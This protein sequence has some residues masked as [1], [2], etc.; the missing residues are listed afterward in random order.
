MT[1]A[2]CRLKKLAPLAFIALLAATLVLAMPAG[3]ARR[4]S[5]LFAPTAP[6]GLAVSSATTS[7]VSL[8]WQPSTDNVRVASYVT[9]IGLEPVAASRKTNVTIRALRC[10]TSYWT[11]VQAVDRAGNRSP[12]AL[13]AVS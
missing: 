10:G 6:T 11:G 12:R 3:A 9:T 13:M 4:A 5:D 8:E 2:T 1:A 7:T